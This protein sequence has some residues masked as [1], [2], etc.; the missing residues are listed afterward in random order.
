MGHIKAEAVTKYQDWCARLSAARAAS[1]TE[2]TDAAPSVKAILDEQPGHGPDAEDILLDALRSGDLRASVLDG[3]DVRPI[4]TDAWKVLRFVHGAVHDG[5]GNVI[6]DCRNV[7]LDRQEVERFAK[8]GGMAQAGSRKP[9]LPAEMAK[10][11]LRGLSAATGSTPAKRK[12][13]AEA[14]EQFP[15][16][17]VTRSIIEAAHKSLFGNL[18][19][20]K[21]VPKGN[22]PG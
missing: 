22:V 11:F 12:A 16:Y 4:S 21:R 9:K 13:E 3:V 15:K 8:G 18:P 20:G 1:G 19:P 7:M 17:Q 14:R 5:A 2:N 10:E 6:M